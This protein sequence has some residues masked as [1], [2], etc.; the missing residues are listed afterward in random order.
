MKSSE[1]TIDLEEVRESTEDVELGYGGWPSV[2]S[3][4]TKDA[5]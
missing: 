2:E 3:L 1:R 4:Q 5:S